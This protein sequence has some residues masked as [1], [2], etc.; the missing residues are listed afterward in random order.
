MLLSA[1]ASSNEIDSTDVQFLNADEPIS[2]TPEGI[3]IF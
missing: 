2:S 1:P 3:I